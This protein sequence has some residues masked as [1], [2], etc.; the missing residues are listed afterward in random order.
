MKKLFYNLTIAIVCALAGTTT[1]CAGKPNE[2]GVIET[3]TI[4]I[5]QIHRL[6]AGG[7]DVVVNPGRCNGTAS[8]TGPRA[9]LDKVEVGYSDGRLKVNLPESVRGGKG[10]VK[11]VITADL[12]ELQA[13]NGS[14]VRFTGPVKTSGV[15]RLECFA[16]S[17]VKLPLLT[18][19]SA[20]I[21]SY[22][23]AKVEIA[24]MELKGKLVTEC[25]SRGDIRIDSLDAASTKAETYSG[26]CLRL[27][28]GQAG[29]CDLEAYSGGN[30]IIKS[31]IASIKKN[32]Y[33]G[34]H[35]R[36]L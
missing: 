7:I 30:I 8:I 20:E 16:K 23:G 36:V 12:Q 10:K 17:R 15:F 4:N 6:E 9:I 28:E 26:G 21:E 32:E 19:A 22:S 2:S 1:A 24:K 35:I 11:L 34:G 25:Y 14:T 18:G 29:N 27:N 13:F 31:D 33:S 5:S 3:K